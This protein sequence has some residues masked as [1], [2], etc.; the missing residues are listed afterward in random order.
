[1]EEMKST[2]TEEAL[3]CP[4]QSHLSLTI[5]VLILFPHL[6]IIIKK[7]KHKNILNLNDKNKL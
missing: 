3:N 4:P 7:E 2:K 5:N 6:E 1:M